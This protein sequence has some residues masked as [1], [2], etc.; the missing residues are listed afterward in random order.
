MASHVAH[1]TSSW[2]A[3]FTDVIVGKGKGRAE[4]LRSAYQDPPN[5]FPSYQPY[6]PQIGYQPLPLPLQHH[7]GIEQLHQTNGLGPS[8]AESQT[9][10]AAFERALEDAKHDT[11]QRS[12]RVD[13]EIEEIPRAVEREGGDRGDFEAVW[14]SL[15]PE[16]ERLNQLAEW[17]RDFSQVSDVIF[18]SA[19]CGF[20]GCRPH[21]IQQ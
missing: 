3:S 13:E 15:R 19:V 11:G 20:S 7:H 6:R 17:E 9:L 1:P 16:A 8:E 12:S 14:Q 10:E 5:Q 21:I 2:A 18:S 4:L